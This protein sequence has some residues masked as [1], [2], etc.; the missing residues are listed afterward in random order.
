MLRS[1]A[2]S[3][4]PRVS[5]VIP[6][7]EGRRYLTRS[8]ESILA[9][10]FD[11]FELL[12]W[13]DHSI[14]G[15][16][17][18]IQQYRDSRIRAH[19]QTTN[20]GLFGNLNHALEHARGELIRLWS[21]DD[22]MKPHCLLR[23]QEFWRRH[24]E[25]GL[26]YC[27]RSAIDEYAN[28][29][30]STPEDTTP[31]V[32]AGRV[33]DEISFNWGSMPGNISTVTLPKTVLDEVGNY[34]TEM[35]LASDFELWIRI[36]EKYPIGFVNEVLMSLRQHR[37]QLSRSTGAELVFLQECREIYGRLHERLPNETRKARERYGRLVHC[38]PYFHAA[39]R[40]LLRAQPGYAWSLL[41]EIHRWHHVALVGTLWLVS[42]NTRI[43]RP[44]PV[45][46]AD[47][48]QALSLAEDG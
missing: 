20:L 8:I 27:Q 38:A 2:V 37:G 30:G 35:S 28:L 43:Y 24:P 40:A 13:D 46:S 17:D 26:F 31:S 14:D 29:S 47:S 1:W 39:V 11:D 5:V 42:A 32:M 6:V 33:A 19:R 18:L 41:K 44:Q 15:S 48:L 34:T 12:V 16:W 25:V 4:K 36:H 7:Y 3:R 22:L 45:Y 21:Q 10:T 23:E 9:Q